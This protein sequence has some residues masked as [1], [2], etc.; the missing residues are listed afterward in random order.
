MMRKDSFLVLFFRNEFVGYNSERV[1]L[2]IQKPVF[3]PLGYLVSCT[4][5]FCDAGNK[6]RQVIQKRAGNHLK[7]SGMRL[8]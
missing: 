1:G 8:Q 4:C 6:A 7:S 2:E 5:K 3:Q